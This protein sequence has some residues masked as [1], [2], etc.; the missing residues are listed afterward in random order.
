MAD[1]AGTLLDPAVQKCPFPLYQRLRQE[2]PVSYMPELRAYYVASYELVREIVTDF[3]RFAKKSAENDGRRYIEPSRAAQQILIENDGGTPL[4]AISQSN[5]EQHTAYRALVNPYFRASNIKK[6]E[7]HI[8]MMASEL[9]D[10]LAPDGECEVVEAYSMPLPIYVIC[11]VL[12]VPKSMFRTFKKW[13]DAVLTY[14]AMIVSE[15]E[16]IAGAKNMVELHRYTLE[17]VKQRRA[18][19]RDDLLTIVAQAKYNDERPLTDLEILSFVDELLVAGN[20][21]TTNSIGA[22]LL[23]IAQR[24]HL[25]AQLRADLNKIP[26]FVEEMLRLSAPLQLTSRFT[27]TDVEIGGVRIPAGSTIFVGLASANRDDCIYAGGAEADLSRLNASTHLTF[28][29]GE[30]HCLGSE[31]ARLEMRVTFRE[32]LKRFSHIELA[33]DPDTVQYPSSFALRGPLAF[34]LKYTVA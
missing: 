25:Q 27:L 4:N 33:Q 29:A 31:L 14:V 11:D 1:A 6:L 13:S 18:E 20:E 23:Y 2:Q 17:Q 19:P 21:T 30:H 9:I 15:E 5:G 28:G 10:R 12:G 24:P 22:G 7:G 26:R 32:W 8:T 3:K 34:R 16:A